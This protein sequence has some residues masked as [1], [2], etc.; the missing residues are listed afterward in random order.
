MSDREMLI[1]IL[2]EIRDLKVKYLDLKSLVPDVLSLSEVSQ[3]VK[4]PNNTIRKYLLANFEP[5]VDFFK[6]GA[7]IIVK[8]DAVL[9]IRRHYA[10]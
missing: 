6:K 8:Q 7:K 2:S 5:E 1:E 3:I 9:R 4:K 10:K